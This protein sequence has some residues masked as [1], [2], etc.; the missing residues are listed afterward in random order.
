MSLVLEAECIVNIGDDKYVFYNDVNIGKMRLC[1]WKCTSNAK[2]IEQR[3]YFAIIY[4]NGQ[5]VDFLRDARFKSFRNKYGLREAAF[6][7]F[8][9]FSAFF[10]YVFSLPTRRSM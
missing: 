10:E 7:T 2:D 5:M 1:S 4:E 6:Y 9:G 3:C 8:H